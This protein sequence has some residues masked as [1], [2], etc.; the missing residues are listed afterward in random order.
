MPIFTPVDDESNLFK[1][2]YRVDFVVLLVEHI[3]P[4]L[5]L[6]LVVICAFLYALKVLLC[7]FTIQTLSFWIVYHL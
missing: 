5:W 7:C 3:Q 4:D 2:A 1:F 6:M